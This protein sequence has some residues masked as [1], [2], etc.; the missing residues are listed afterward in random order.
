M[1]YFDNAA[2]TQLSDSVKNTIIQ[3]LDTYGNPSSQYD[4]GKISKKLINDARRNIEHTLGLYNNSVIFTSGGSESD[5]LAIKAGFFHGMRRGRNKIIISSVEHHAVTYAAEQM[6]SFGAEVVVVNVDKNGAVDIDDLKQKVDY[7]TAIVSI[8]LSNNETG[9][10]NN[11]YSCQYI[12]HAK[13]ALLHT[14]AVQGITHIKLNADMADMISFSGH[15]FRAPKGI[16]GLYIHPAIMEE[17]KDFP[18]IC[19]GKQEFHMRAGT[20]NVPYIV[21]LS[22]AVTDLYEN[23]K[24]KLIIEEHLHNYLLNKLNSEFPYVKINGTSNTKKKNPSILNFSIGFADAASVVEYMSLNNIC[25]SSGSA[26]NTG[27]PKPS[28]VLTAM[29]CSEQ[30]A[31]SS[32]R[33][34]FSE[35]NSETDINDFIQALKRFEAIFKQN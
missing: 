32:I 25:I 6:K 9:T 2:T 23:M 29:G 11:I 30:E 1:I 16:G 19:G 13:G 14:D 24:N 27:S 26:C 3:H 12:A 34:S 4:F 7:K 33:V 35:L 5:N 20:E 15:K 28:H 17:I 31:F 8:M 18:L 21:G 22:Q 10:T